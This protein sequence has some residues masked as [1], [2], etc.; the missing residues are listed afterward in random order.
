MSIV[1]WIKGSAEDAN[2]AG[3]DVG[4]VDETIGWTKPPVDT[5]LSYSYRPLDA[6]ERT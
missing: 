3:V 6:P 5:C 4:H 1:R 2:P